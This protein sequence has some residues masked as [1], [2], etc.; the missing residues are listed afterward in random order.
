MGTPS[1]PT[2]VCSYIKQGLKVFE[3]FKLQSWFELL[4]VNV[5]E[6]EISYYQIVW[7]LG[8]GDELPPP[9][10]DPKN[11]VVLAFFSGFGSQAFIYQVQT[12]EE[13]AKLQ[14]KYRGC[15][16]QFLELQPLQNASA[17][18]QLFR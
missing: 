4:L 16:Y 17:A 1:L 7:R 13:I 15:D 18:R 10:A 11:T 6:R 3:G 9:H 12:T 5:T 14:R 8:T 2:V